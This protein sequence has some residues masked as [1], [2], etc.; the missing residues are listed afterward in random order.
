MK[1]NWQDE[2]AAR[3]KGLELKMSQL[4]GRRARLTDALID[5]LLDRDLFEERQAA[6]L[7]EKADP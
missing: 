5:G 7:A 2:A 4:A 1:I 3:R 6:L